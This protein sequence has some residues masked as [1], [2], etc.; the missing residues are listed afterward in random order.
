VL[1]PRGS[2]DR[3]TARAVYQGPLVAPVTEGREVGRLRIMRG[4]AV[5]LDQPLYAGA[6]V[7]A[8]TLQQRAMD[9]ALE[10]S[11]GI[12]RRAFDKAGKGDRTGD[13]TSD[14]S[15]NPS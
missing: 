9:A 3:V 1:L 7:E 8:G 4:D 10:F 13:K 15:A 5:A 14:K 2:S 11:T 6:S 12:V